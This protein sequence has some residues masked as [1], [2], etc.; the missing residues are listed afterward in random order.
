MRMFA[1]SRSRVVDFSA[2]H[3][4]MLPRFRENPD[5]HTLAC[6]HAHTH[7]HTHTLTSKEIHL[8]VMQTDQ[9]RQPLVDNECA[10]VGGLSG[11]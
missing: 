6:T 2:W 8:Q 1:S 11:T 5:S 9:A 3:C 10:D 4:A 7:T